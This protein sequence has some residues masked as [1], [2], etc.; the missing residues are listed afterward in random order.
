MSREI[1][2]QA[3]EALKLHLLHHE[4]GCVYLNPVMYALE[5]ALAQPEQKPCKCIDEFYCATFDRCKRNE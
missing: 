2:Q 3:L 4:H 1:M 5:A